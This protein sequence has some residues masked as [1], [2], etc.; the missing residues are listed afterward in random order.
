M[1]NFIVLAIFFASI[2]PGIDAYGA[3]IKLLCPDIPPFPHEQVGPLFDQL[4]KG[5]KVEGRVLVQALNGPQL[6]LR[7]LAA[8]ALGNHGPEAIPYLID[9]LSDQSVHEGADYLDPGMATTRHRANEA[10]KKLTKK[11]F[12]FSWNDPD[13]EREQA[14]GRWIQWYKNGIGVEQSDRR[15]A[16]ELCNLS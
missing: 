14:I 8:T 12:N 9:A 7:A 16:K 4:H 1:R 10:L 15:N 11:D 3:S 6:T 13:S 5:I 2:L